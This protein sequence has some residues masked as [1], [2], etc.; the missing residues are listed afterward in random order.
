MKKVKP[1]LGIFG[2][3]FGIVLSRFMVD[4][5]G[6]DSRILMMFGL[7]LVA[8]V[9]VLIIVYKRKYFEALLMLFII[10]PVI[11]MTIGMYIDNIYFASVGFVLIFIIAPIMVKIASKKK[12]KNQ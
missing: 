1:Y 4:K 12:D 7:S 8:L 9:L 11:V 5:Y 3:L 6:E 2:V 10:L